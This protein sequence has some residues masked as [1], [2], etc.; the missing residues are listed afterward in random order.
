LANEELGVLF[1]VL[2]LLML[3]SFCNFGG[4]GREGLAIAFGAPF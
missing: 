4:I 1:F 3:I 2:S